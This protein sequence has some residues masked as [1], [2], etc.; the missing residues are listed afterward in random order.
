[1]LFEI[2]PRNP[3]KRK[4][5]QTA[6]I[7]NDGGLIIYPTDTIYGLGC[8]IFNQKAYEKICRIKGLKPEKANFSFICKDISDIANYTQPFT[9]EVYKLMKRTLPGPFTYILKA[10]KNIPKMFKNKKR[11]VGIRIPDNAIAQAIIQ[12]LGRPILSTSLN[13]DDDILEYHTD[14]YEIHEAFEKLVDLVVD[15][16]YGKDEPSTVVD[17]TGNEPEIIR[18]G[19]GEV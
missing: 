12:E 6:Q 10:N 13:L 5:K 14:P 3:D 9:N 2:N 17:C 1:M 18:Q 4:I 15:G 7:L 16:G 11:T 8:D 19:A